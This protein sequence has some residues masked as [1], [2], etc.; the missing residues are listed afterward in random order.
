MK[1]IQICTNLPF[2]KWEHN[3]TETEGNSIINQMLS[4][5]RLL[6]TNPV[7]D[8]LLYMQMSDQIFLGKLKL[9]I[10]INFGR[11]PH[12]YHIQEPLSFLQ[13]A[14]SRV[15]D[16]EE[17][18][19]KK[20]L[21]IYYYYQLLDCYKLTLLLTFS[22]ICKCQI[23]FFLANGNSIRQPDA[24]W[25]TLRRNIRNPCIQEVLNFKDQKKCNCKL[26]ILHG[27]LTLITSNLS[28]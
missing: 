26:I 25:W 1:K 15:V 20:W 12:R 2:S 3:I 23:R 27:N 17:L 13:A 10:Y 8:I 4:T 22:N 19:K 18:F 16:I 28:K 6:S 24:D 21:I 7:F 5:A 11:L 14:R 9:S